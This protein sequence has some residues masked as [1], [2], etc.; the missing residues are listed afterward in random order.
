MVDDVLEELLKD[1][2]Y[3]QCSSVIQHQSVVVIVL[4]VATVVLVIAYT[5][6]TILPSLFSVESKR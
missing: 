4:H 5:I 2:R 3:N 1:C 6:I